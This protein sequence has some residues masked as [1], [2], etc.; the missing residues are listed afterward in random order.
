[1]RTHEGVLESDSQAF[2]HHATAVS[3]FLEAEG[4]DP[5]ATYALEMAFEEL[6]TNVIKYAYGAASAE[7][8]EIRYA[9]RVAADHVGLALEDDGLPFDPV[10]SEL[11]ELPTRIEE[12]RIGGLGLRVLRRTARS[13][14]YLREGDRNRVEI[15]FATS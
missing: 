3:S 5:H 1:M 14:D 9:V 2:R 15:T 12:A 8:R 4:V 6:V 13:F 11:P 10:T 7:G